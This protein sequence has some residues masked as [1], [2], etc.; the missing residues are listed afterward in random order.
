MPVTYLHES[1]T[2]THPVLE[3]T[4]QV[5]LDLTNRTVKF[6]IKPTDG[7]A[8]VETVCPLLGAAS[9]YLFEKDSVYGCLCVDV[10]AAIS[11]RIVRTHDH[12]GEDD[13]GTFSG[14]HNL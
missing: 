5:D 13:T 6:R 10:H 4:S 11:G 3:V 9:P 7:G 12:V 1:P 14:T 2:G 8:A